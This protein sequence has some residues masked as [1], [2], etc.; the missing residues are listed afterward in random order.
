MGH[1][2]SPDVIVDESARIFRM[3]FHGPTQDESVQRTFV[4]TSSDGLTF[5]SSDKVLGLPYFRVF[6]F[7]GAYYA[8]AK[9]GAEAGVLLRSEDGLGSFEEGPGLIPRMRHAA[10]HRDGDRLVVFYSRIGDTPE[11]LL[12]SVVELKGPWTGWV[13][14]PAE[15]VLRPEEPYEGT[16]LPI[17][18]SVGGAAENPLHELRDPALLVEDHAQYLFYSVAG[19]KG[20]AMARFQEIR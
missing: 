6:W 20:L 16:E 1:I 12:R 19:E 17:L 18:T 15:E 14:S 4:A 13:A 8:I 3:Y 11:R 10:L 2:A 5:T 7:A 9:R